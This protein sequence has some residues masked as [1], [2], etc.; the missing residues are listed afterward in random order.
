MNIVRVLIEFLIT[1]IVIYLFYY[2]FIIRK[3]KKNKK[4]VPVEVNLILLIY[5]IDIKKINLY[6]MIKIVSLATTL[7]ISIIITIISK[8]FNSTIILLLFGSLI[9]VL[10][11]IILYQIIGRYYLKKSQ[12]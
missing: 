10:V 8:F 9:S 4:I 12:K 7:V 11:A 3:C 2:F 6:Q 5:K 1:F